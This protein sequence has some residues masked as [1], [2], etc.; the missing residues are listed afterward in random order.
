MMWNEVTE[1]G[2]A[3]LLQGRQI[4]RIL[5]D[6]IPQVS[7]N[8]PSDGE[9]QVGET[10]NVWN[11]TSYQLGLWDS[12]MRVAAVNADTRTVTFNQ[13]VSGSYVLTNNRWM[14]QPRMEW[15]THNGLPMGTSF[16][17]GMGDV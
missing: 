17:P 11:D 14:G 3:A 5:I 15:R 1:I 2:E 6:E 9:W 4:N 12:P 10:I 7:T 8:A 13:P 16:G